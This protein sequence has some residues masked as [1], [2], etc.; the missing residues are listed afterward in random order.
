MPGSNAAA[1]R[2]GAN[3]TKLTLADG[4]R[5]RLLQ[6]A[7][8]VFAEAGYHTATVRQICTRAQANIALVNYYFGDKLGLYTEVLQQLLPQSAEVEAIHHALDE[9]APPE[10]I[11]RVVIRTRLRAVCGR[12]LTDWRFRIMVHELARPTPALAKII[13]E[14]SRPLYERLL[15][16]VGKISG[17]P[18]GDEKTRLC[19]HSVMGQIILYALEGPF[20]AR[21]WPGLKMT[22][23]QVE[24]IADHIADFSLAYLRESK[25]ARPKSCDPQTAAPHRSKRK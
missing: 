8:E 20:L 3:A 6:A 4:T 1:K 25:A 18:P 17:L 13:N 9:H 12:N 14:V 16:L 10:H 2:L 23:G 11:L 5:G 19:A 21:L 22:R 15:E 24:R 7:G